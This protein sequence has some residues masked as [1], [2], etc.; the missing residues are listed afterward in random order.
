VSV[1]GVDLQGF[2]KCYISKWLDC[3]TKSGIS[4]EKTCLPFGRTN[5]SSGY[6]QWAR[7]K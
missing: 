7:E 2:Y 5:N 3:E 4:G 6:E 1:E